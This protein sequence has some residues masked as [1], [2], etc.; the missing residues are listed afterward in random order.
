M[1][2]ETVSKLIRYSGKLLR[3][4]PGQLLIVSGRVK[5]EAKEFL[6]SFGSDRDDNGNIQLGM[7]I[8]FGD[9]PEIIR[10]SFSTEHGWS[11]EEITQNL[12]TSEGVKNPIRSGNDFKLAFLTDEEKFLITIDGK[13]FCTFRYRHPLSDIKRINVYG[14]VEEIYQVE[15]QILA[16]TS[17]KPNNGEFIGSIP[18][19]KAGM[20]IVLHGVF[21]GQNG[22]SFCLKL[23]DSG[24]SENVV[25][26]YWVCEDGVWNFKWRIDGNIR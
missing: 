25:T 23:T 11:T 14:D 18:T 19:I 8:K 3:I 4:K 6:V 10:N 1:E 20:A 12:L 9:D 26:L 21:K 5:N 22:E 2:T 17:E 16:K 13:T 24:N 7:R 15:H